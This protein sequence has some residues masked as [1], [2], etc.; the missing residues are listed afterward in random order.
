[1]MLMNSNALTHRPSLF[2]DVTFGKLAPIA[3][4]EELADMYEHVIE[5]RVFDTDYTLNFM[6]WLGNLKVLMTPDRP[7]DNGCTW[8]FSLRSIKLCE[9][10]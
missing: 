6:I 4:P 9:N 7:K 8:L 10:S 5:V 1:M 2:R 3:G